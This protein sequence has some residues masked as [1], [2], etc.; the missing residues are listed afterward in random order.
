MKP[1]TRIV[2]N[3]AAG[4]IGACGVQAADLPSGKAAHVQYLEVCA[5]H[6]PGFFY[7][8]STDTCVKIGGH[9]R[10][11]TVV[12]QTFNKATDPLGFHAHGRLAIELAHADRLGI[13]ACLYAN[14]Y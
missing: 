12:I 2:F 5:V 1:T 14:Q 6:G 9:V 13:V 4:V 10:F 7:I 3:S 11:E 8:P